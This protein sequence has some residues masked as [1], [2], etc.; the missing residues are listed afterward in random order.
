MEGDVC[1]ALA[2]I[3]SLSAA[4]LGDLPGLPRS[5]VSIIWI[6]AALLMPAL[7]LLHTAKRERQRRLN[8]P[9]LVVGSGDVATRVIERLTASP[10][11]GLH[12]I[13]I[14]DIDPPCSDDVTRPLDRDVPVLGPPDAIDESYAGRGRGHWSS[15]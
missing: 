2:S 9:T 12:P 15:P 5:A 10:E 8:T 6:C 11:Y 7:P 4:T 13:G 3:L 14:I 1:I